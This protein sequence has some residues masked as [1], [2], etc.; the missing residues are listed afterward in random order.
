MEWRR[1]RK[2][3]ADV[4]VLG[5]GGQ[6][7]WR[8]L[9][10]DAAAVAHREGPLESVMTKTALTAG[11]GGGGGCDGAAAAERCRSMQDG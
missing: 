8:V 9:A 5:R 11:G 4:G 10:F 7:Q 3:L 2:R 1:R 6:E